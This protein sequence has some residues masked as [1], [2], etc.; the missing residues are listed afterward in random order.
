MKNC[1]YNFMS[2]KFISFIFLNLLFFNVTVAEEIHFDTS[3]KRNKTQLLLLLP[4]NTLSNYSQIQLLDKKLPIDAEFTPLNFWNNSEKQ[5]KYIRLLLIDLHYLPH[6]NITL[7]LSW[8]KSI[9]KL[10]S[11]ANLPINAMLIQPQNGWLRQALLLEPKNIEYDERWYVEPQKKYASYVTNN[12]LLKSNGY[13][14]TRASQWLYDRPRAIYQL[15]LMSKDKFWLTKANEQSEFYL[16]NIDEN[17][18]FKLINKYD[19]KYVFPMGLLYYYL[20]T[21]KVEVKNALT[22]LYHY[23]L[24]WEAKYTLK[25]GFWTERHQA[26]ALL[27]AVAYWELTNDPRA[28]QRIDELINATAQMTFNPVNDWP[29]RDCPQHSLKSHEGRGDDIPVCSPWM[30]ALLSDALWRYYRLTEDERAAALIDVFGNFVLD[31]GIFY[32]KSN[33]LKGVVMPK[34]LSSMSDVKQDKKSQWTDSQHIYDVATLVGRS[35]YIKKLNNKKHYLL[36]E[37]FLVFVEYSK[38]PYYG[39]KKSRKAVD[40]LIVKPPRR[41]S[42]T[43]STTS[44]LPWLAEDVLKAHTKY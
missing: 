21:G 38:K 39:L 22:K 43:Y 37:L 44:D 16:E 32:G 33:K 28:K 17:G 36:S 9:S 19:P 25:R 23:S 2:V 8:R 27:T 15:Y 11:A 1:Q 40:Y 14:T 12:K 31:Y 30:M 24:A 26:T 10:K 5:L 18:Q 3:L 42:W 35:L 34:Y 6:E 29:L 20:L 7:T 13:P 4:N 41:F